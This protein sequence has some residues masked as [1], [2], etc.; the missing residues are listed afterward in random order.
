MK[1]SL[2]QKRYYQIDISQR[3]AAV[4]KFNNFIIPKTKAGN[5]QCTST[6]PIV[7]AQLKPT[8]I[9]QSITDFV[10]VKNL[11]QKRIQVLRL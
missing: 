5:E 11:P 10:Y 8:G 6:A 9:L 4:N 7:S 2:D 3:V 1:F